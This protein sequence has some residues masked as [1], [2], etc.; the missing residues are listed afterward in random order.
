MER[1]FIQIGRENMIKIALFGTP[2]L[3]QTSF[4]NAP[5][6]WYTGCTAGTAN[7]QRKVN[8]LLDIVKVNFFKVSSLVSS[9]LDCP[10]HDL[11]IQYQP[12]SAVEQNQHCRTLGQYSCTG[13]ALAGSAA[14]FRYSAYKL[15]LGH[16]THG[17]C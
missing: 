8:T 13:V 16:Q 2:F 14:T 10:N 9:Q 12:V 15:A 11:G 3:C 5:H 1:R 6:S 17:S 7:I 4:A